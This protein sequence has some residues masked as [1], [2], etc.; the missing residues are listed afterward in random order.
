MWRYVLKGGEWMTYT[1]KHN[2]SRIIIL[3]GSNSLQMHKRSFEIY[4]SLCEE[5]HYR[6]TD[7]KICTGLSLFGLSSDRCAEM[8]HFTL[9]S[10]AGILPALLPNSTSPNGLAWSVKVE[11]TLLRPG[12][13]FC[14]YFLIAHRPLKHFLS[15]PSVWTQMMT[16]LQFHIYR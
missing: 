10:H 11:V 1:N 5:F 7:C 9:T 15:N 12:T 13:S 2:W 4:M 16:T 3:L 14:K 8:T 6:M